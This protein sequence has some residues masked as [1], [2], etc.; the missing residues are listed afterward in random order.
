M[1]NCKGHHWW[2]IRK[3]HYDT[4]DTN[5][6]NKCR[7]QAIVC[8]IGWVYV[9][10]RHIQTAIYKSR[11]LVFIRLNSKLGLNTDIYYVYLDLRIHRSRSGIR[12][13]VFFGWSWFVSKRDMSVWLIFR[14]VSFWIDC[15][16]SCCVNPS[17]VRW[18]RNFWIEKSQFASSRILS[19]CYSL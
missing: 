4:F 11:F 8:Q 1:Y 6:L 3:D 10:N 5:N 15:A 9:A 19:P 18:F 13:T 7:R 14:P 16:V 2:L 17:C 12:E